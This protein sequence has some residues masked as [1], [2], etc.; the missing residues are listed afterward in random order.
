MLEEWVQSG[1]ADHVVLLDRAGTAPRIPGVHTRTIAA[2]D[3]GRCGADSLYL[4]RLCQDLGADLFVSTYY[5]T[6]TAT[7]SYFFGYDM[8]PEVFGLDLSDEYWQEKARAIRHAAG[9]AMI[10][11]SS[12]R[13]LARFFPAIAEESVDLACFGLPPAFTT[14]AAQ[15]VAAARRALKLPERYALMVGDR[16]GAGGYKNGI[17]AFRAV[18]EAA[19]RGERLGIVCI[20]G[21]ADI[22]PDFRAAAL[23]IEMMR[24]KTDDAA[25]RLVYAGAHALLYPSRYEGFGMPVL[26]AMACGCPVIACPNSSLLEVGGEAAVFVEP[27]DVAGM[28]DAIVAL[29]DPATRAARVAAG[30]AQAARFTNDAQANAAMAAFRTTIADLEAGRR[31]RPGSGWEEFRRYQ[32]G[33]QV[34]LQDRPDLA[35][36]G[37]ARVGASG[38]AAPARPSGELLRALAEIEMIKNS[39]FWRLRGLVIRALR[40]VGLRHR[41]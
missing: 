21:L 23:G 6:P 24:L 40:K 37:P 16:S 17:L 14:A 30:I 3:H 19:R 7:P 33:I 32:A 41:G 8:I 2:H 5:T 18:A 22:E 25:L 39:P 36:S 34:W 26:E 10:S 28:A 20:G 35:A 4:E 29:R 15:D 38:P 13:D 12:A 1:L 27:D 11:R 9:H 31:P